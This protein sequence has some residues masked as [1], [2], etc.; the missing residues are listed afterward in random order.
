[1]D[2]FWGFFIFTILLLIIC[3]CSKKISETFSTKKNVWVYYFVPTV[4]H[5]ERT[6]DGYYLYFTDFINKDRESKINFVN[7]GKVTKESKLNEPFIICIDTENSEQE[8]IDFLKQYSNFILI[9]KG[10]EAFRNNY[11]PQLK[12]LKRLINLSKYTFLSNYDSSFIDYKTVFPYPIGVSTEKGFNKP[13]FKEIK[14]I[15]DRKYLASFVGSKGTNRYRKDILNDY[16]NN[17]NFYIK[18]KETWSDVE[19]QE[20]KKIFINSLKDSKFVL[21]L[22]GV[23]VETYRFLESM[24][25]G[26]IPVIVNNSKM[27]NTLSIYKYYSNLNLPII[28][29]DSWDNLEFKL[30]NIPDKKL[31]ELQS[32]IKVWLD[33]FE[34]GVYNKLVKTTEK[35]R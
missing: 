18:F 17:T 12:Y 22:E 34:S 3:C 27:E 21:C 25:Y 33:K 30:S 32:D 20:D 2:P 23:N 31:I 26:G 4:H 9:K 35:L 29:L 7:S 16:L 6:F 19:S 1:M 28:L 13:N 14:P 8:Q 15:L 5:S 10:H 11:H 24:Y